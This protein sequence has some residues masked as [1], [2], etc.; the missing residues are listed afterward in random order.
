MECAVTN[1]TPR[2]RDGDEIQDLAGLPDEPL[3]IFKARRRSNSKGHL[4]D[5]Y[6]K[7][8]FEMRDN[9]PVFNEQIHGAPTVDE[10]G[11]ELESVAT[12]ESTTS[13]VSGA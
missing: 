5:M 10:E 12:S 1:C 7:S 3:N 9:T 8:K 6:V 13:K 11:A 2:G 4:E